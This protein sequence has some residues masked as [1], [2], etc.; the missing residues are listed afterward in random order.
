MITKFYINVYILGEVEQISSLNDLD[1]LGDT[2]K[3]KSS[4]MDEEFHLIDQKSNRM[5]DEIDKAG[6]RIYSNGAKDLV[7]SRGKMVDELSDRMDSAIEEIGKYFFEIIG[8]KWTSS[9]N[10]GFIRCNYFT[11]TVNEKLMRLGN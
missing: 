2:I 7:E 11:I 3:E 10:L 1:K 6:E 8:I 4:Q 9:E 5:V